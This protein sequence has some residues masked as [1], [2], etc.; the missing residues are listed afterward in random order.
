MIKKN[1]NNSES[2]NEEKKWLKIKKYVYVKKNKS[3]LCF[4]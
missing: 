1:E 3:F 2:R 4:Y